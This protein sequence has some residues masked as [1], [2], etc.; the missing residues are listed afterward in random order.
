MKFALLRDFISSL[1]KKYNARRHPHTK[2]SFQVARNKTVDDN[3]T[4]FSFSDREGK[5]TIK[6]AQEISADK[7]ILDFLKPEDALTIG[8]I[9]GY[10]HSQNNSTE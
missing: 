1:I 10:E 5:V 7:N 9:A 4:I 8:Y 2:N 3:K 6:T